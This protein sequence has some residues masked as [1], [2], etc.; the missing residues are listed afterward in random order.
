[1]TLCDRW[2]QRCPT[3]RRFLCQ[4]NRS[5][6]GYIVE[7]LRYKLYGY[8]YGVHSQVVLLRNRPYHGAL[9]AVQAAVGTYAVLAAELSP[10]TNHGRQREAG[11][12]H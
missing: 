12:D 6:S 1:M 2:V 4:Y 8:L 10:S 11:D 3:A 9:V 5:L 7:Q